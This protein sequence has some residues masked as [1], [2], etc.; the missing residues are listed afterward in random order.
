[1]SA[2]LRPIGFRARRPRDIIQL[3]D[4]P[5]TWTKLIVE[6][7]LSAGRAPLPGLRSVS[8]GGGGEEVG[9]VWDTAVGRCRGQAGP[10]ALLSTINHH[11]FY[12]CR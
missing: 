6:A 12:L 3:A 11:L 4:H 7:S 9:G 8:D 1:M 2:D 5:L 10:E